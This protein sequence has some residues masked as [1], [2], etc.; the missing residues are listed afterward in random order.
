MGHRHG[1]ECPMGPHQVWHFVIDLNLLVHVKAVS[2]NLCFLLIML[3]PSQIVALALYLYLLLIYYTLT[4]PFL[5]ST[6]SHIALQVVY[7]VAAAAT[8][9]FGVTAT[10]G[11]AYSF[12]MLL[13]TQTHTLETLTCVMQLA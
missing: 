7:G 1:F 9:A 2:C 8:L 4:V 6:A 13:C 5:P 10:Y 3:W 12:C 11:L